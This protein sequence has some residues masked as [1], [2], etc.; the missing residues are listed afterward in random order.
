MR[1]WKSQKSLLQ[2]FVCFPRR[3]RL[4]EKQPKIFLSH[5]LDNPNEAWLTLI[6]IVK[7]IRTEVRGFR[8]QQQSAIQFNKSD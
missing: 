2:E 3:F 6:K 1:T 8:E 5:S 7:L 4:I